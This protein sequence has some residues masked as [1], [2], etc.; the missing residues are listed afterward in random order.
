MHNSI[1]FGTG[2]GIGS[3]DHDSVTVVPCQ[4]IVTFS[5]LPKHS[6][7]FGVGPNNSVKWKPETM[8]VL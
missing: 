4:D 7:T 3:C 1:T 5:T 6:V 8:L 2:I